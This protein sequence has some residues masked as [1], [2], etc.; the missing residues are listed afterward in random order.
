MANLMFKVNIN[1]LSIAGYVNKMKLP[2]KTTS[3]TISKILI[4]YCC[5]IQRCICN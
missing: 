1:Q 5:C 4:F 3:F 2:V